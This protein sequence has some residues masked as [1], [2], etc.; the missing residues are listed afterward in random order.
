MLQFKETRQLFKGTYQYKVVL[1]S[2]GSSYF[3]NM[4]YPSI[5]EAIQNDRYSKIKKN[6]DELNF[7]LEVAKEIN[8]L[9]D[10]DIRVE[11]PY[12]SIYLNDIKGVN[13]LIKIDESKVKYVCKPAQNL[14]EGTVI[15]PNT[16]FDYKITLSKTT[17]PYDSFV[18]WAENSDKIK[19]TKSSKRE[20]LRPRSWGGTH[21]YVAGDK[22]L[23]LVKMQ[24]SGAISKIERI[25][26]PN[27]P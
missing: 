18:E 4:D 19:L 11:S 21:L 2:S 24:L 20:L 25:I 9:K 17:Q 16:P 1:I 13:N 23:L 15:M 8:K 10:Y 27:S 12:I 22:N 14:Q 3:R 5:I 6:A 26:K 7:A